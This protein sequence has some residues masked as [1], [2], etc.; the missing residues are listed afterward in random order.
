[1]I[2]EN[3]KAQVSIEMRYSG[4]VVSTAA[5]QREGLRFDSWL[6]PLFVRSQIFPPVS[7]WVSSR[8]SGFLPQSKDVRVRLI[9]HAKLS[10]GIRGTSRINMWGYGDR[11]WVGLWLVQA[12]WA[13][14][15]LSAL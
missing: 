1:M 10:L 3:E 4:T 6:G 2:L 15:P 14:W 7:A 13:K 8:C 11:A 9:G 5:S 12:R